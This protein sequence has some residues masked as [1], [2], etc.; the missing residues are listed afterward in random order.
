MKILIA[1]DEQI[2]REHLY[3]VLCSLGI[4]GSDIR[5][6]SD[7]A[8]AFAFF[9]DQNPDVLIADINMPLMNGLELIEHV[10]K[11]NPKTICYIL[12]SYNTFDFAQKAL[13]I[14]AEDYLLKPVT[15]EN[16]S[17]ILS[18]AREEFQVHANLRNQEE[19][20]IERLNSLENRIEMDCLYA[21][22]TLQDEI[23]IQEKLSLLGIGRFAQSI[24]L[25]LSKED[26][27]QYGSA[28]VKLLRI[29]AMRFCAVCPVRIL[30]C[31][32]FRLSQLMQKKSK[33]SGR[34]LPESGPL[35]LYQ[36]L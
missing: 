32:C 36:L 7:G 29:A 5:L 25:L 28:S 24:C 12:S 9:R 3:N 2:E 23:V 10:H 16:L 27:T 21:I 1:E 18:R 6:A 8:Q 22:V 30:L 31:S 11:L 4:D 13:R 35:P 17:M 15:R 33:C 19:R 34:W 20:L 26:G 14:G